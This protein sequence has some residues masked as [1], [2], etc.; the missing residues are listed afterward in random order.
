[1][2]T[3]SARL[4][5]TLG[6]IAALGLLSS[7]HGAAPL[8]VEDAGILEPRSCELEA[9]QS[10]ERQGA[11]VLRVSAAK[12]SCGIGMSTQLALQV[13]REAFGE[14]RS[15][16]L[17]LSGKT[18]LLEY[19][20]LMTSLSYARNWTTTPGHG[21]RYSEASVSSVTTMVLG[22]LTAHLNAGVVRARGE[23]GIGKTWGLALEQDVGRGVSLLAETYG[24][25]GSR[26]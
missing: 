16:A 10:R 20:T 14:D 26:P 8:A 7:A 1:M 9:V 25:Q 23:P 11:G 22:A 3:G 19:G 21:L 12:S 18:M 6:L 13:A 4:L 5:S 2:S 17:T 24:S 15:K